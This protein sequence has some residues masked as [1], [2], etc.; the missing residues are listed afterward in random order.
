MSE[1]YLSL[2]RLRRD[3]EAIETPR[4]HLWPV[5]TAAGEPAMLKVSDEPEEIGRAHV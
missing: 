1:P 4:A 3:G 5:L 2:W